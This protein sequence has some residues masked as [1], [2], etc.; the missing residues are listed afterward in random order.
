M[1]PNTDY[2]YTYLI[3]EVYSRQVTAYP[4][5]IKTRKLVADQ[6]YWPGLPLD[7]NTYVRNY[8]TY[9]RTHI[10]HNKTPGL[11]HPLPISERCWQ[12]ISFDFKSFL[13]DKKGFNNVFI[14]V[15]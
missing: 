13:I 14:V 2:L 5:K 6:Y 9:R 10:P 4:G 7:C 12:Y 3:V 1:V 8:R 11:L 15:N